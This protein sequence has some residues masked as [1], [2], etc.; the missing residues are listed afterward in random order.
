M[1]HKDS[2]I[3]TITKSK[4]KDLIYSLEQLQDSN[5]VKEVK[6]DC[7]NAVVSFVLKEEVKTVV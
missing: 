3:I 4:L 2:V 6:L 1:K 7:P 5:I